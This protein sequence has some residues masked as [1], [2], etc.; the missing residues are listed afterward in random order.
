MADATFA[1]VLVYETLLCLLGC[2]SH[3]GFDRIGTNM[4]K[5]LAQ[6]IEY[7]LHLGAEDSLPLMGQFLKLTEEVGE[8]AEQVNYQYGYL[9]KI[10]DEPLINEVADVIGCALAVLVKFKNQSTPEQIADKLA[11]ALRFKGRKWERIIQNQKSINN[12][13]IHNQKK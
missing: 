2:D 13:L 10:P 4:N 7:T 9:A 12:D 8:L 1:E 5:D 3:S 11:E 6:A